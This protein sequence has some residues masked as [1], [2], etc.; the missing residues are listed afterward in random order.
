M[1]R[2]FSYMTLGLVILLL[3]VQIGCVSAADTGSN[4]SEIWVFAAASLTGAIYDIDQ[5]FEKAHPGVHIVTDFDSS[6]TL[7]TQIKNGAPADLFLPAS[8]QNM[9]NLV[10]AKLI[11]NSSV[12]PIAKGKLA[13]IVPADNPKKITELADLGNPGVKIVSEVSSVPIR[14]YTEQM[15]TKVSN[16]PEYGPVFVGNFRKNVISEETNV[17]QAATKVA[18]GEADAGITY[19]SDVTKD[20]ADKVKII[21]IPAKFNVVASYPAGILIRS[22]VKDLDKQYIDL[23]KSDQGKTVLKN[24]KFDVA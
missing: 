15:L 2:L 18:M 22:G 7:E 11:D 5:I 20:I 16:D 10:A 21:E 12:T 19:Y 17:A 1:K 23:L 3:A 9:N 13:I 4:Q 14:K 8:D 24:Y 6:G